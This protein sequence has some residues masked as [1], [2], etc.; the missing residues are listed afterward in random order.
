[1]PD[2]RKK[3]VVRKHLCENCGKVATMQVGEHWVCL[4]CLARAMKDRD[5]LPNLIRP[6]I[7]PA[8]APVLK[9]KKSHPEVHAIHPS[10][11]TG[12]FPPTTGGLL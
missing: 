12:L 11:F 8:L 5:I 2:T 4:D 9:E 3:R 10:T 7:M 1:M 6:L